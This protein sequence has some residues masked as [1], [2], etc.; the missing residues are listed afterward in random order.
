MAACWPDA[1]EEDLEDW[2]D[3]LVAASLLQRQEFGVYRYHPLIHGFVRSKLAPDSP[4]V[5]AYL[6]VMVA[7]AQEIGDSPTLAQVQAWSLLVPHGAEAATHWQGAL[8]DDNLIWPFVGLGRFYQG[9]GLYPEAALWYEQCLE[10]SRQRLGY[11]PA[12]TLR[13]RQL[14]VASSLNNLALLYDNQGRYAEAEPLY[15]QAL[16]LFRELLGERH[17]HVATSLNNLAGLYHA[18]GRYEEAEPLYQKAL[19]LSQELLGERHPQVASSL[20]NLG[21]LRYNQGR[22]PEALDLLVEAEDILLNTLGADHPHTQA[23]QSWL[24]GT[25]AALEE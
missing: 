25:R 5:G 15:Q 24:A 7:A 21:G 2:Q 3:E 10:V 9:Q 12:E 8:A 22:Y 6:T 19:E 16:Q 13:E 4:L 23:L 17:P 14:N 20:F 18:Q 1:E 11:S